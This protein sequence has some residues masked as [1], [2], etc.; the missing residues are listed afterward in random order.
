MLILQNPTNSSPRIVS[1]WGGG[2][3]EQI[4]MKSDGTVWDWGDNQAGELGNGTINNADLPV[5]VLGPGGVG[6]L[7]PVAAIQGGELHNT[8]L[9]ANGTV[10][11]WGLNEYGQLGDGSTNWG[12]STNLSTTPVQVFGLT[13]V[14]SLGGRGYHTLALK[15]DG[16]VW[17]WGRN[18]YGELGIGVAFDTGNNGFGQATNIPVQVIGL[19]N[20]ASL[21]AGG[22]FSLALMSNGTVMAWGENNYGQCGNGS[23]TD[24]LLPVPVQGLT[25]VAAI[26]G[27]WETTLALLSNGTVMAWGYN[28]NGELG[29]G[30]TNNSYS[31]VQV[32]GLSNIVSVWEGDENSMALRADGTVWKWGENQLGELGNGTVDNGN[33]AHPIPQQV[34]GLS[35]IVV[36]VCRDYHNICIQNNGNVW[37]WGDNRGGGCGNF[38]SNSVL[39]PILMP[40]LVSN[41]LIPYQE[42]FE[43]YPGGF[44]LVGTNYWTSDNPNA[45]VVVATNYPYSGTDPISGPQ[46]QTLS[47]N[48]TVTNLFLPSFYTN[49]WVD[50]IVQASPLAGPPPVLNNASFAVCVTTNGNLAVWDCTNPPAPGNGWTELQDVPSL[51]G[52]FFRLTIGVNYT[53]DTNG[54]FYYSVYVNGVALTNLAAWYAAADSSQ[55][56]F[57]QLVASGNFMIDDLVVGANNPFYVLQTPGA[58]LLTITNYGN[59]AVVSWPSSATGWTLQTNLNLSAG[60]WGN[61]AGPINNNSVTNSPANGNLFFRLYQ[62]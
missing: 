44:S 49:V 51:A 62:P 21:S 40:G 59:Q 43:S 50:L 56:W 53:P 54:L 48:G 11:S 28:V 20:P 61:Y 29:D 22:F 14:K 16:T 7:A 23:G 25:N 1:M 8:A 32:I 60:T 18:E 46:Q 19:T 2:G 55:P 13:N 17:A 27:G 33:V 47:I 3:S 24:C 45:A 30:T 31:P 35:N 4:V 37:V 58:P 15:N 9:K 36:A 57:G 39:S 34:P 12:N 38:T 6:Y 52:Q 42:S 5:Q 26:S 41:N 10:W